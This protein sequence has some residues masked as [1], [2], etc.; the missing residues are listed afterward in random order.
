MRVQ[1]DPRDDEA[2]GGLLWPCLLVCLAGVLLLGEALVGGKVLSQADSLLSKQPWSEVAPEGFQASNPLLDDQAIVMQPWLDFAAERV[3]AG[4]LPLWN[5]YNYLGQ[6]IHAANTGAFFWP[7]HALYYLAPSPRWFVLF[8]LAK[9]ALA[10]LATLLFLRRLLDH[11]RL[12][13]LGIALP[14]TT[15]AKVPRSTTGP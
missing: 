5:P 10:G 12:M 15:G 4:E 14:A 11:H 2:R 1:S 8:A 3:R 7:P 13:D 9:I 6:P